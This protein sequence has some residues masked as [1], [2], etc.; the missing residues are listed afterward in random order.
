MQKIWAEAP[1]G[2][3]NIVFG[4]G[5]FL[6]LGVVV[7]IPLTVNL[8]GGSAL[9][10]EQYQTWKVVHGYGVFLGF[11]NFFFGLALDRASLTRQQ[12]E[13]CSWSFL[14]AGVL[15]GLIRMMLVLVGGLADYGIYASLGESLVVSLGTITFLAGQLRGRAVPA[16]QRIQEATR[17][18]AA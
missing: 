17:P 7:G 2:K 6:L 1:V 5:L 18:R 8:F 4:I 15:G 11:I 16:A 9:T 10:P 3:K 13:L 12:Q 14:L